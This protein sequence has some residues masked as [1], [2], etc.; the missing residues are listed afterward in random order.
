MLGELRRLADIV[1]PPPLPA[2][3]S[4]D[5]DDNAVLAVAV[6]SRADLIISGDAD[7]PTLGV[8]AGISIIDPASAVSR[9]GGQ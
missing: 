3:I 5:P 9:V 6:A 1:E 4:R 8:Y 7:L 2:P